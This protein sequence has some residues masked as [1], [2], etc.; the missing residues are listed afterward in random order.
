MGNKKRKD[1]RVNEEKERILNP[2]RLERKRQERRFR[3]LAVCVGI[4]AA[5][6]LIAGVSILFV[7]AVGKSRLK[8]VSAEQPELAAA[9]PTEA[10]AE[11]ETE[12]WQEGWVKYQGQ[13]YA[14]NEDILTFLFMGI[15]K[16]DK[17]VKKVAEGTN[18]GQAD[19]LFLLALDP[20]SQ[21]ASV[22]GINRNTMAEVDIYNEEGAYVNTVQAQI[23]VQHGFGNGVEESCEYQKEAVSRLFY[24]LPIHGY[25]A[26]NMSAIPELNDIVGGVDVTV[27]EDMTARVPTFVEGATV[28][29][30]GEDALIY[31]KSRDRNVFGSADK[32]LARQKQYLTGFIR[33]VR[34]AAERDISTVVKLYQAAVP[35]M[36]TDITLDEAVYLASQALDYSLG[37]EDFHMLEGESVM[38]ERFEEYYIDE[39]ALYELILDVFYEPVEP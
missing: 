16:S 27:L 18:G 6:L 19:A 23:A 22:I 15:D 21:K 30:E 8:R 35:M 10:P 7:S 24:R 13:I 3:I 37:S 33:A 20:H 14:Y 2:K 36:T 25:A 17:T 28:H 39:T 26:V 34:T 5:V 4:P 32:R 12:N 1:I 31:V 9:V 29:L 38:G 11:E